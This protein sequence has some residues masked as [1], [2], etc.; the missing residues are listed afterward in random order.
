M[1]SW[2]G[3]SPLHVTR[4]RNKSDTACKQMVFAA[5]VVTACHVVFAIGQGMHLHCHQVELI[6][7]CQVEN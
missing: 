2:H 6:Y 5:T 4:R 3:E 7:S 1:L